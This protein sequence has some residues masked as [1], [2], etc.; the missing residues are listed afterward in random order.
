[1]KKNLTLGLPALI[2]ANLI[3]GVMTPMTKDLLSSELIDG[4][5]LSVVRMVSCAALFWILGFLIP[6]KYTH[7]KRL[8]KRDA[9]PLLI[10]SILF[11]VGTQSLTNI[12]TQYTY[13]VDAAVCCCAAPIFTLILGAIFYHHKFPPLLKIIG[14]VLGLGGVLVFIFSSTE[15][16]EMHVTNPV[17]GDLL[18]VLSQASGAIYLVFYVNI[19][20]RYSAFTIMKWLYTF[21]AICVFPFT[22]EDVISIP[23][24]EMSSYYLF[25]IAFVTIFGSFVAYMLIAFAQQHVTPTI[26]GMCNYGQPLSAAAFS[27]VLGIAVFTV[28]SVIATLLI[29]VGIWLVIRKS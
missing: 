7:E 9:V 22:F 4:M 13:A 23:W 8:E 27:A 10:G 16:V 5:T 25:T 20:S 28:Q 14:V 6:E 19:V 15:N 12:G 18:C 3:W 2:F 17:L 26:I 11:I 29:F 21:S 24:A 1:M